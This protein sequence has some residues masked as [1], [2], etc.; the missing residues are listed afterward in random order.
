MSTAQIFSTIGYAI[1]Y[2]Y[3]GPAG[4]AAGAAIGSYIGGQIDPTVL[5][6]Q[7]GPRI[8][9]RRIQSSSYGAA[10][11]YAFGCIRLAGNVIWATDIQEVST[12][13]EAEVGGKGGG[14]TQSTTTFTYF[15]TFAVLL[16]KGPARGIRR[17]WADSVLIFDG[18]V[19]PAMG[20]VS[21][22]FYEGTEDQLPDPTI[23][24]ALG[25]G[26]APAFRGS[27]YIVFNDL[28][29]EKFGN[30]IPSMS[31]ELMADGTFEAI[32]TALGP[33]PTLDA[34]EA[35]IDWGKLY[36]GGAQRADGKVIAL[37]Y[38]TSTSSAWSVGL[39]LTLLDQ[40]TGLVLLS[41]NHPTFAGSNETINDNLICYVPATDEVWVSMTSARVYRF[42]ATTLEFVSE[43]IL[44]AGAAKLAW[45]PT[46]RRVYFSPD[47]AWICAGGRHVVLR[48]GIFNVDVLRLYNSTG[49]VTLTDA[50]T[51]ALDGTVNYEAMDAIITDVPLDFGIDGAAQSA[52]ACYDLTR[53]R[54]V[55]V[56]PSGPRIWTVTDA[57]PPVIES[58]PMPTG[59]A[60]Y[61]LGHNTVMFDSATDSIVILSQVVGIITVTILDAGTFALLHQ[62]GVSVED[63]LGA[64]SIFPSLPGSLFVLGAYQ[65]WQ[66][67]YYTTTVGAAVSRLAA[68]S[69]LEPSDIDVG[70]LT[71]RLRGYLVGNAGPAGPAVQQLARVFLFE[72]TE[73]NDLLYF[74][75]RGGAVVATIPEDDCGAGV[76]TAS[77]EP[78]ST[79]RAQELE[80]PARVSVTA[81]DPSTDHQPGTQ[82]AERRATEVGSEDGLTTA[83]VL[84]ADDAKQLADAL[85]FD[86]WA[87]RESIKWATTRQYVALSPTDPIILAGRRVRILTRSDEGGLISWGGVTDDADVVV[88]TSQG[89]QGA[90]PGQVVEIQVPTSLFILDMALLTDTGNH[91]GAYAAVYGVPPHW[92]GAMVYDSLDSGGTWNLLTAVAAPGS[93]LGTT[94]DALPD[95]TGGNVFDEASRVRVTMVNGTLSST[96]RDG[97]LAGNNGIAISGTLGWEVLQYRT[98]TLE[99]DGSYTL[100]GLLRG[101][102]GTGFATGG[103]ATGDRVVAITIAIGDL[104]IANSQI[105]VALPFKAVTLGDSI[106][107]TSSQTGTITAERL[108]PWSPVD[109]RA[110]RDVATGD[111]TMTWKRRTRLAC[112]FVGTGGINVPLG[113]DSEAYVVKIYDSGYTTLKRTINVTGS[114]TASYTAAQQ[115]TDFG[116]TQATVYARIAMVSATVGAGHS[117]EA[118]A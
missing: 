54:Y 72:S 27:S 10:I 60:V 24:A 110:L 115:T 33:T 67:D 59:G 9:D 16:C 93:T 15:G 65:P 1:G 117:L 109:F 21:F 88:Q 74:R 114:A 30:R 52:F 107:A 102:R 98:A 83:V 82:Y 95:W 101:R 20:D 12:T 96:T 3:G 14:P 68:E 22:V 53:N 34:G 84:T 19:S 104:T 29:L 40:Y 39:T 112:R 77:A 69:G 57:D 5:P 8:E 42:N 78:I 66:L 38:P 116:S 46:T 62:S 99:T 63:R 6:G 2:Y 18:S 85:I 87:S 35:G 41:V 51:L 64:S 75:R 31:V 48:A 17:I 89:V 91:P 105:G 92:R 86:R 47:A 25:V 108:K 37:T 28:A 55:I 80:L 32:G 106:A 26:N 50:G 43:I 58:H 79:T 70:E 111:I 7:V 49:A 90:F 23:E 103:H 56:L 118:A 71:Q 4:G 45:E 11:P 44:F 61:I 100:S 97:V 36:M 113:E 13:T 94:L 76:D 81:P 73:E